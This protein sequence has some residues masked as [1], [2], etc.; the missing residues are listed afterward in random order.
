MFRSLNTK[1]RYYFPPSCS[2]TTTS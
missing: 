1:C 2:H